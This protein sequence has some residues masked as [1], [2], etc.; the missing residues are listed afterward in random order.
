[1]NILFRFSLL[2][3]A[4][5]VVN[6]NPAAGKPWHWKSLKPLVN[7]RVSLKTD[8]TRIVGGTEA[9]PHSWPHQVALFI[10]FLYF[11]GGSL[12]SSEWVLTAAHCVDRHLSVE[13]V[14]GAHNIFEAE[15]TQVTMSSSDF[16]THEDW[17]SFSLANDIALVRLPTPVDFTES[18]APVKLPSSDI[19]V[20]TTATPTGWGRPADSADGISNVLRQVDVPVMA[21]ED[22]DKVYGIIGKGQVCV[23]TTGGQGT[24]HGDSGGPL[25]LNGMTYGVTSFGS[26][27]GCEAGEPDAFTRVFY[28]LDWIEEKTGVTP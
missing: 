24:C 7:P 9:V 4:C 15:D 16:F 17:D 3:A 22:C 1:M 23:D 20:G 27:V 2:L 5:V 19:S 25:N 11:C 26:S 10:D 21:S 12:I 8:D 28:Y 14:L 13:V 18:I 6:G